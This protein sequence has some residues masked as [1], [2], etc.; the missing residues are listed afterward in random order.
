MYQVSKFSYI[1]SSA[2]VGRELRSVL[3]SNKSFLVLLLFLVGLLFILSQ[4]WATFTNAFTSSLTPAENI[5]IGARHMF[6]ALSQGHLLLFIVVIPL[7]MAPSIALERET[8]TLELLFSSPISMS[9]L[10]L[11]KLTAPLLFMILLLTASIPAL[12]L[13]FLGGGLDS[14]DVARIYLI[15]LVTIF[16]LSSLGLFCSTLRPKVYEVYLLAIGITFLFFFLLPFHGSIWKY[17]C[18]LSWKDNSVINHDFQYI[19]PFYALQKEM[20]LTQGVK[21]YNF[22][23]PNPQDLFSGKPLITMTIGYSGLFYLIYSLVFGIGLIYLSVLRVRYIVLGTAGEISEKPSEFEEEVLEND[24]DERNYLITFD[25]TSLEGNPSLT[26]EQKVQW[27]ARFPVLMRLF[28]SALMISILTLPLASYEGSWLYLILPFIVSALFTLPLAATSISI[29][30]Q[31][32]TL[33]FLRTSLLS[34]RQIVL[35]KFTTNLY[36]SFIIAFALYLPG[37][38]LQLFSAWVLDYDVD[39]VTASGGTLSVLG[40]PVL[41]FC[42]LI[43]YTSLGLFC[44]VYFLST[45]RA[46]IVSGA[47]ILVSMLAPVLFIGEISLVNQ[48]YGLFLLVIIILL[49]S[50]LSGITALF[51]PGYI[52]MLGMTKIFE[53][54]SASESLLFALLQCLLCICLSLFLLKKTMSRLNYID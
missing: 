15:I 20:F 26:L 23:I 10:I 29:D 44:S 35:A 54:Y 12:S 47:V 33:D 31:R 1:T 27:F 50:P 25:A 8:S 21:L 24:R 11:A 51:P 46:M 17:I 14:G 30:S 32:K 49:I 3:R 13:C 48:G 53:Q 52:K 37:M 22:N 36:Y 6:Y 45:T 39:L 34:S 28:Y 9:H 19:S 2:L 16:A 38:L 40:Y 18:T 43:L 5:S 4:N 42:C 41:L 7:I